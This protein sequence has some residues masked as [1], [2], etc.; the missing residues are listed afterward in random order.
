M[1]WAK[2]FVLVFFFLAII[3]GVPIT[4]AI[5]DIADEESPQI[6]ELFS[7]VPTEEHLRQFESDLEEYSFFEENIRPVYQLVRYFV[8]RG[9]GH[10]V[11][12]GREGWYFYHPGVKYFTQPYYQDVAALMP[13]GGDPLEVICDF[14][15]QMRERGIQVVVVPIPGKASIYPDKLSALVDPGQPVHAHTRRFTKELRDAG[16]EVIDIHDVFLSRR[17]EADRLNRPLYMRTDTHWTGHGV[18]LAAEAIAGRIKKE[19]WYREMEPPPR[20]RYER[21]KVMVE[22]RGDIPK[23]T[24]IPMQERLFSPELVDAY[25]VME[26]KSR[27]LYQDDPQSPVLLLGDSFSRVFQ[28]DAPKSAG[29]IANLAYE[30]QMPITTIIN[31]GGASTLV[32][33]QLARNTKILRG[34][35]LIIWEFVERDIRFG[36]RGWQPIFYQDAPPSSADED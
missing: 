9:L 18:I 5:L 15:K 7:Q 28:T 11:L 16:V 1:Q 34:K 22:R 20:D 2:H 36:M 33:Q 8:R 24:K 4:Q 32:R 26:K 19:F 27:E 30:L 25:Q 3:F 12:L 31:D 21:I 10:K 13:E 14:A 29:V 23:M 35:R 6:L 17:A